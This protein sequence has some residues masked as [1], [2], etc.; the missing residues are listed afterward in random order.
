MT[1]NVAILADAINQ[2]S[3]LPQSLT[4]VVAA[5]GLPDTQKLMQVYGGTRIFIPRRL[6]DQHKLTNLLG[7]VQARRL[8]H[9]F[10]GERLLIARGAKAVRYRR[11][12]EIVRRYGAGESVAS[13]ARRH[14]LTERQIYTILA[15]PA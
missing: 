2:H 12:A 6:G 4:S 5:I 9:H 13:L 15:K 14:Q 11:N 10:G 3:Q 1:Y 7:I 8:S